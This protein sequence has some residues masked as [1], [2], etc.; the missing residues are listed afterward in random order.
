LNNFVTENSIKSELKML[1]KI[2]CAL[3][4][5]GKPLIIGIFGR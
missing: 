1:V 4:S 2:G 5:V 3:G